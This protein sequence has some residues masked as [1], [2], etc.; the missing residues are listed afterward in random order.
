M[1]DQR[2][3]TALEPRRIPTQER[4]RQRV[5][6]ILDAVA[7][8]LVERGFDAVTT[9][10]I[11]EKAGIPVGSIYQFFPNKFAIFYALT[12][13]Y[14]RQIN[15]IASIPAR[16]ESL[17]LPWEEVVDRT[18]E[19]E[20]EL[21]SNEKALSILWAGVQMAPELKAAVAE[22]DKKSEDYLLTGLNRI[23]PN[24]DPARRRLAARVIVH[25]TR[26]LLDLSI[27][28]PSEENQRVV[29][30]LKVVVKSYLRHLMEA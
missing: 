29:E 21:W 6:G 26:Y 2:E 7:E 12:V 19:A 27:A 13:R 15:A 23:L 14:I 22:S 4:S 20:A 28:E 9:D 10:L 18:I 1:D 5:D 30:E 24:V 17:D 25:M 11:A 16:R 8:L 3:R